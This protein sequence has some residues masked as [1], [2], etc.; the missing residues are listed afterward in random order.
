MNP[1]ELAEWVLDL[2]ENGTAFSSADLQ[3]VARALMGMHPSSQ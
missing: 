3:K 2:R 1:D